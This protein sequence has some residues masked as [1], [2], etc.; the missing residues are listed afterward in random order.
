MTK[1]GAISRL[2]RPKSV[3]I[4]G[5]SSTPGSLGGGVLGNL[6]RFGFKGDIHL[7]NPSR[8]DINGRP[9]LKSAD[10]LPHG[11]DCAV[12]AIPRAGV[13]PAL[14]GCARRGVGGA[15]IF[16]SGFAEAGEDGK[17]LQA[18]ICEI[19]TESGMAIEGPNCLGM[20]N[21]IDGAPLTFGTTDPVPR[22]AGKHV[23]IVSQ[24]GAMA[25]VVRAA[26]LA[27]DIPVSISISTG[28]EAVNGIEDFLAEL[29]EDPQNAVIVMVVEQ[30]RKPK[31]F[32]EL[33]PKAV[34]AGKK[35]V[36]LHPGRSAAAK[37]SAQTHTGALTGDHDVMRAVVTRT[38][39]VVVD[40]LEE[41]IDLGEIYLRAK[42]EIAP[43]VAIA[44]DSG[45]FKGLVLDLCEDIG[46]SLP[47]PGAEASAIINAI[48]PELI[49][50]TNPLDLTA[51]ALVDSDLYRKTMAPRYGT[52][53]L[54]S[55]IS[56]PVLGRRKTEPVIKAIREFDTK[57]LIVF[58]MLG[59]DAEMPADIISDLRKLDVPF[60]RSPE[61]ALR[62]LAAIEKN[63]SAKPESARPETIAAPLPAGVMPEYLAK[64]ELAA[65]GLK[66]PKG[67]LAKTL[68]D[69]KAIARDCGYPVALK[70]Q[71]A[72]LSHKSD[73]GGVVLRL[74]DEAALADGWSRL[75]ANIAQHKPGLALDGVLVESMCQPGLEVILGARRDPEW[76]PVLMIGLGGVLTEALHD[77]RVISADR[78]AEEI[79]T[80]FRSLRGA[81]LL[82]A[83]RGTK[84]RD[85]AAAA[86]SAARLGAFMLAHPE[87]VEIDVNPLMVFAEG[88]GALALD[89]VIVVDS[90]RG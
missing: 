89:A 87:V 1:P 72:D 4:F 37:Q 46:L 43:G 29:I 33:A 68:D 30:F 75:A 60:F 35:I 27:R 25:T 78:S 73:V 28:N 44:T 8:T 88:E 21:L 24:S 63:A 57:K 50:A 18:R 62:A 77:V 76:G 2:L 31:R 82:G 81:A 17:K 3:A 70:A 22:R 11:V 26:L 61:R 10:E 67:R 9:C 84:A 15:I 49:Q 55:I 80:E 51:H 48:A 41:L 86:E 45:A 52:V 71:S 14:E 59:E 53:V 23:A 90:V 38:G 66:I 74:G 34:A 79:M 65:A 54:A 85:I 13:I 83:F 7:I 36:V 6:E 69:A 16:A 20:V 12:L 64:R 19:A 42:A 40:T 56:N 39:A 32:L 58:A 5:A 47:A